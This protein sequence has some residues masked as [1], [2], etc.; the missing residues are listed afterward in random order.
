VRKKLPYSLCVL[1][2]WRL[3]LLHNRVTIFSF[4]IFH[5]NIF[6]SKITEEGETSE[7]FSWTDYFGLLEVLVKQIKNNCS[8]YHYYEKRRNPAISG[9]RV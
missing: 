8:T 6:T 3:P 4:Y 7:I 1:L 2:A 9:V 5:V